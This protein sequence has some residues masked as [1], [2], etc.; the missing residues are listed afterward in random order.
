MKKRERVLATL[1]GDRVDRTPVSAW[2]HFPEQDTTAEGQV[3]AFLDFQRRYD[4][5]FMKLMFRSTFLLQDWGDTYPRSIKSHSV[6]GWSM[7][8]PSPRT[9]DWDKLEVLDPSE[10]VLGEMLQV[11]RDV[12]A[13]VE[14]GSADLRHGLR[15][16][17]GGQSIERGSN[18]TRYAGSSTTGASRTGRD[19]RNPD[20]VLHCPPGQWL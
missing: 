11:V 14:E 16:L 15:T 17:D 3:Q 19:H 10:G 7:S 13:A 8:K 2:Q 12:K 4:W 9:Q 18:P 20:P 6:I 5:D 1:K